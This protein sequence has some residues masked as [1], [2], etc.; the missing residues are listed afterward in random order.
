[1]RRRTLDAL[2]T[3]A[4]ALV[5]VVA[6][7]RADGGQGVVFKQHPARVVQPVL[8]QQADDLGNI[9]VDGAALLAAGLFASKAMIGFVHYVQCHVSSPFTNRFCP[10]KMQQSCKTTSI[11]PYV[12]YITTGLVV[13]ARPIGWVLA[14]QSA[15]KSTALLCNS[16]IFAASAPLR[17]RSARLVPAGSA[18]CFKR[19]SA[20][21][22]APNI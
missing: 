20:V 18:A 10:L 21:L 19:G 7:Q 1:M 22:R 6:H 9:G 2:H 8:F 16:L 5:L 14:L 15:E 13:K 17:A 11:S 4:L 3:V 12:F